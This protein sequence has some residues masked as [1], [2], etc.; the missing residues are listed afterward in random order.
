[1]EVTLRNLRI[2]TVKAQLSALQT[3]CIALAQRLERPDRLG[4]DKPAISCQWQ[5]SMQESFAL[6]SRLDELMAESHAI[7][8]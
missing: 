7:V 6:Q 5:Q 2:Q 1:M 8:H 3:E 4:A